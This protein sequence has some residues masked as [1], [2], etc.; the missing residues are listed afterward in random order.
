MIIV[1]LTL[2]SYYLI[3]TQINRKGKAGK[4]N[5][6]IDG[7][8]I[9]IC[10]KNEYQNL[11]NNLFKF[12]NQQQVNYEIIVVN[13][14]ST[15]QT[16]DFLN[17][18]LKNNSLLK[19]LHLT[20]HNHSN[21]K[22]KRYALQK[23]IEAAKYNYVALTDA[24]CFPAGNF[25]LKSLALKFT[26]NI[27]IVLGYSP[28]V[29]K[30]GFLNKLIQ[31]ETTY[32]A[33]QYLSF[34][35]IGKP[36]MGVGRNLAYKKSILTND[37]FIYSN[38]SLSGDDD[39]IISLLANKRNTSIVLN[40]DSFVYS[41]PEISLKSWIFQKTRHYGAAKHYSLNKKISVG[42]FNAINIIFY[43]SLFYLIVFQLSYKYVLVLYLMKFIF[44]VFINY[45]SLRKLKQQ[46]LIYTLFFFDIIYFFLLLLLHTKSLFSLDGWKYKNR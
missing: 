43:L 14:G 32:T 39:L 34:A 17:N 13:D 15:D 18:E 45:K 9:V 35:K 6:E 25:W 22:G 41:L 42:L 31:I 12:Y 37:I 8:S 44:F 36:Y 19:V 29:K 28:Y 27:E 30:E 33:L 46:K 40:E 10:A 38:K 1:F 24:D 21:L 26:D 3:F 4:I 16:A 20:H 23:G 7:I 11:K 5:C 2:L